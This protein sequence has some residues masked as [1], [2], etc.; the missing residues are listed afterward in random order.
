MPE[1]SSDI[2]ASRLISAAIGAK[3]WDDLLMK[4][5]ND[6]FALNADE[7]TM[8][9]RVVLRAANGGEHDPERLNKIAIAA[10][11]TQVGTPA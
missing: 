3:A 5:P 6:F 2:F 7:K 1:I 4:L 10:I 11:K 9:W 8:V